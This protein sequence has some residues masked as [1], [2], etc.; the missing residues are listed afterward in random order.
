MPRCIRGK[1]RLPAFEIN[2]GYTI[3]VGI[4]IGGFD[5]LLDKGQVCSQIGQLWQITVDRCRIDTVPVAVGA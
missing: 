4:W 3:P 1:Y 5:T 2:G